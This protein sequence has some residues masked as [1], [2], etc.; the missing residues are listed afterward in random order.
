[1]PDGFQGK[2]F[3]DRVR[4]RVVDGVCDQVIDILLIG[5]W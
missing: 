3:K 4:G 2:M 5:S 1:M